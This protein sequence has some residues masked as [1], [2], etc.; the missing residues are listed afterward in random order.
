MS[1]DDVI[2][3]SYALS[4]AGLHNEA[5]SLLTSDVAALKSVA[6]LDLLARLRVEQGDDA[7]ARLLW[8]QVLEIEPK[9]EGALA[10][11][12]TLDTPWRA[13]ARGRLAFR[14]SGMIVITCF[15]LY[16]A[17]CMGK[18][19]RKADKADA[20]V[21]P[22]KTEDKGDGGKE[23]ILT[24]AHPPTMNELASLS[25]LLVEVGNDCWI[26][27]ACTADSLSTSRSSHDLGFRRSA[28][29]AE[30]LTQVVGFPY[31]RV[32]IAT[33]TNVSPPFATLRIFGSQRERHHETAD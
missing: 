18:D 32:L 4:L 31:E 3:R 25:N 28:S 33:T 21:Q 13:K 29:F 12:R 11:I 6:G 1:T 22:V 24:L 14:L 10:A 19:E 9:H 17:L 7:S 27:V 2:L 16:G 15:A 20:V 5:E 26:S 8:Q 23:R 30:S